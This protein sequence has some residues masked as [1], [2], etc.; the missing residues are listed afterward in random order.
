MK[1]AAL[2]LRVSTD[3]QD[4]DSQ[5]EALLPVAKSMGY[6]VSEEWIFGQHITGKDDIRKG[7]RESIKRLKEL[8]KTGII[9]VI[10]IWEVSRLS[11]SGIAG[12]QFIQDF[13]EMKIPIFFKDRNIWTLNPDTLEEDINS[14]MIIGLYLDIAESEL[15]TL[16]DRT[17]RGKRKN[18]EHGLSTGG[19]QN[20]GYKVDPETNKIE[21]DEEE[22]KFVR[23]IFAKYASGKYS[24]ASLTKYANTTGYLPRYNKTS[25]KGSFRTN[26][27][28]DRN[29]STVR[30]SRSV[31]TKMLHNR[32]Y[33]GER[34]YKDMITKVPAIVDEEIFNK[35]Q[36][37]FR[38]NPNKIEKAKKYIHLLGRKVVC[39]QCGSSYYSHVGITGS[40]YLCTTYSSKS[41]DCDNIRINYEKSEA[42]VWD[43][44]K[45]YSYYFKRIDETEKERITE[46]I[47]KKRR[48]LLERQNKFN[49]LVDEENVKVKNLLNLVKNSGGAFKMEDIIQDKISID[50]TIEN[51]N[52]DLNKIHSELALL[53]NRLNQIVNTNLT[54][55]AIERIEADRNQMKNIIDSV[56]DVIT[57]YKGGT[58]RIILQIELYGRVVNILMRRR[59]KVNCIYC[60]IDDTV[61]TFQN[62]DK[63]RKETPLPSEIIDQIPIFD[64]GSNNNNVFD[65]MI[66]GG[67]SFDEMWNILIKYG[68][69]R[70]YTPFQPVRR[71]KKN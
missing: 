71:E 49:Q 45:N 16:K 25:R 42:V 8:C 64:V 63:F 14:K 10:I 38:E 51:Y 34:V 23:D 65:E 4:I 70:E 2:L 26:S 44:L 62:P 36:T 6:N 60:F 27:G 61:A 41:K 57:V 15:K 52:I 18:V 37:F 31:I 55:I 21:I 30:W 11:R 35:A 32:R 19:F 3:I 20:Y 47:D 68:C 69:Y 67:Y 50:K 59:V 46:E 7:E 17:N 58:D 13:N 54:N 9:D 66:F 22:A 43:Y 12:R 29:T 33:I 40:V 24:T 5:K 53:D 39:G 28:I 56:I 1:N 48:E